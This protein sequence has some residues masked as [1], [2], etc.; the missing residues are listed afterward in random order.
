MTKGLTTLRYIT[1]CILMF[2]QYAFGYSESP[3]LKKMVK[4]GELP[5]VESRLP[6]TPRIIDYSSRNL[7]IGKYGG[8]IKMLMARA[9]EARQMTV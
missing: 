5:P 1:F 6:K 9:E 2:T 3:L 7:S 4:N 8:T